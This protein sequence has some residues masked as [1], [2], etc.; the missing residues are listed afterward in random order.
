MHH[1]LDNIAASDEV[2]QNAT[3]VIGIRKESRIVTL[4]MSKN[5]YGDDTFTQKYDTD[6][7]IGKFTPILTSETPQLAGQIQT[8]RRAL[9]SNTF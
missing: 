4:D 3:R 9:G 7:G 6:Y 2:G 5:R 8:R 1:G